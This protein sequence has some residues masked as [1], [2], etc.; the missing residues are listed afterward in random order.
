MKT[1]LASLVFAISLAATPP[2][3]AQEQDSEV[4]TVGND[5]FLR[6]YG[7]SGR[8]YFVQISDPSDPLH[9]WIWAPVIETGDGL[10]IS[11]EVDGTAT[12][13][14][15][16]LWYSDQ[17][18]N[19]PDGDDF[20]GDGLS[21]W[22][23]ISLHQ[24]NPLRW[25]SDGDG[26]ND[27]DE[28]FV[29]DTS[30]NAADYD[31]DGLNDFEEV[32]TH[33]SN[34]WLW[35][36]DEDS[37]SD[38]AEVQI[39]QTNPLEMDSDGDWMWDD[40]ELTMGFDPT[41]SADGLQD[42]DHDNLP[43]QLEFVFMDKGYDPLTANSAAA[44]PWNEDPDCDDLTTAVEFATHRTNPR[45]PDTDEDLMPDGWEI[46]FAFNAKTHNS[47]TS[48]PND[49]WDADPDTD[50]LTNGEESIYD[51]NPN[52]PDTDGDGVDDDV[53]I[54]QG[55][56][57]NDPNDHDPPP[58]GTV[59]VNVTFGDDSGSHS[60][61]YKVILT[62][63]EGDAGGIRFR[64]NRQ[65]GT[66]QTDTFQLPKG[67]KYKVELKHTGTQPKFMREYGFSNY[68][69]I[70]EIDTSANC[71][72]V[73]DPQGIV[74]R[75]EEWPNNSFQADGKSAT[76]HVPLFEWV[77][78]KG[79]PVAAPDDAGD[80]QNEFTYNAA[81]PGVLTIDTKVLVK[82]TGTAGVTGH[83]GVKFSDRCVF[84]LPTI[85]GSTFAWDAANPGGKSTASG[86]HVIAKAT[87]TTLPSQNSDFGA[88]QAEFSCDGGVNT[89]PKADF[90]VFYLGTQK[91]HPGGN[92]TDPNWFYYYRQNEGGT[93][94]IYDPTIFNSTTISGVP[95]STRIADSAYEGGFY[96]ETE[97][98]NNQLMVTGQSQI[99]KRY[100][101]FYSV[102]AHERHHANNELTLANSVPPQDNDQDSLPND[103]ETNITKTDPNPG[104]AYSASSQYRDDE[105]YAG[106]PIE[107]A[108]NKAADT[109]QD[110]ANPGTNCKNQ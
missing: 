80:G 7:H 4:I 51:T 31:A 35:D 94:Y 100:K 44:F 102:V 72:V 37:L 69:W 1:A 45:Q 10:N 91:N 57:P 18:T 97:I 52:D 42:E 73:D 70:L 36:T 68:D 106:G 64:T 26:L 46:R 92:A 103:Y 33:G 105:A 55:S 76:L 25:D 104:G 13:G 43:N 89:L 79:D 38:G 24:T 20:D 56:N 107:E 59:S 60:E 32:I 96:L 2:L 66:P 99:F 90:E 41:N 86:E 12:S 15:Y 62:P 29:H 6:W 82:P 19:D 27:F 54:Q 65:Y 23:E 11:Y 84:V 101:Y 88:K 58:N 48:N 49:D 8:T 61:K 50:N 87:Y 30:P 14:F 21:N 74:T 40:R 109:S 5:K 34:P 63:L 16:R 39:H 53:E 95:N 85:A 75:V 22:D 9:T 67:A 98:I 93:D 78:P 47:E 17:P 81:A 110:W 108:A 77:T 28:I 71:L 3:H 83:D